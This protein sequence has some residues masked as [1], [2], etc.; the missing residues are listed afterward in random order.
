MTPT[1]TDKETSPS[2]SGRKH[3][4]TLSKRDKLRHRHLKEN[5]F[6]SGESLY[7]YPLRIVWRALGTEEL[8]SGFRC[9]VPENVGIFQFLISV[10]KKKRRRAVD[11][12]LIRRR[13][14]EAIRLNRLPLMES[15]RKHPEF[16]SLQMAFIYISEKNVDY[17][18]I[19]SR[20]ISLLNKILKQIEE[21]GQ[22]PGEDNN[23]TNADDGKDS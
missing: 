4:F 6:L 13:I 2:A 18:K 17:A 11:R 5:L 10:P 8:A 15:L 9:G 7:E 12:V 1:A 22:Q 23:T 20:T 14:R 16:G 3:I 21:S 19:E